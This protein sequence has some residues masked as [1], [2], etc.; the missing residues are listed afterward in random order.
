M[1]KIIKFLA[2]K[3]DSLVR[4]S[5]DKKEGKKNNF[6]WAV[7]LAIFIYITPLKIV[8][9]RKLFFIFLSESMDKSK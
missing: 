4:V 5:L 9:I 7:M 8:N 6:F 3:K 1:C 2:I